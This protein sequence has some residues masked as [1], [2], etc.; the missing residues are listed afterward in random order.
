MKI[1]HAITS[2][3]KGGAENHLATLATEQTKN[4]HKVFIFISKNSIYWINHL[5]KKNIKIFKSNYFNEKNFLCKFVKLIMDIIYLTKL[6]NKHRPDILHAHLP[7]MEII[8]FVSL[9]FLKYKPKF[10]ITK[11]VDSDFFRGSRD[12]KKTFF[13]SLAAK[14]ISFK[15][16]RVIAISYSVK[17]FFVN[18]YFSI[19]KEKIRVIYYGLDNLNI[20]SRSKKKFNFKIKKSKNTLIIG[21]IARLVPQKSIHNL[22][23]SLSIIRDLNLKLII[24]GKGPL[25]NTLHNQAKNLKVNS[26]ILWF[27]FIDDLRN[28][29]KKIDIFVLTSK[30][31]GFGL[32][33]LEAM[34]S[35]KPVI[36]SNSSAMKEIVTNN[37]NG[38]RV[39]AEDPNELTKAIIKLKKKSIRNK[40][41]LRGYK[42]V[43]SNFSVMKMYK[44]TQEIYLQK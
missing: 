9:F 11:H 31:E 26:K 18:N 16:E 12:Q 22:I 2:L 3:D 6:I 15:S 14:I 36:C 42:F 44:E 34:L 28:F 5:K 10:I 17:K 8:T 39:K 21:C 25:K 4:N 7:Y 40:F 24:V 35:K 13:G 20:L 33:F 19:N 30:F 29:Y 37:Y 32:V 38:F 1:F 43:K 27:D 41:G 23:N